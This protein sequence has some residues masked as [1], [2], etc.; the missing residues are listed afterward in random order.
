MRRPGRRGAPPR[1]EAFSRDEQIQKF[2]PKFARLAD[3]LSRP[4][5]ALELTTDPMAL[6]PER[7][8]VFEVRGS[9][10]NFADAV[11]KVHGLEFIDEEELGADEFDKNPVAYLLVPDAKALNNILAIW[12]RW[13][14]GQELDLG[15]ASWRDVFS[16]L[17][18]LRPWGPNDRLHDDERGYLIDEIEDRPDG[19]FVKLEIE[20][21]FRRILSD[22][23]NAE[24]SVLRAISSAGGRSVDRSRREDIAYH[25]LLVE[26][27]VRAVRRIVERSSDSIAGLEAVMHIRPQSI[28]PSID[29]ADPSQTHPLIRRLPEELPILALIDG[30]PIAAHPLLSGRLVIDDP[31]GLEPDTPAA[32]RV[33]GTAMASLIVHGDRNKSEASLPR[34]IHVVP[35]MRWDGF[36]EGFSGDRLIVDVIYEAV[37]RMRD[38]TEPTA[39][40]VLIVNLSLGNVRRPFH[41][42]MSPWARLLD[43]L[44]WRYGILFI[45]SAGNATDRFVIPAYDTSI[46]LEDADVNVRSANTLAAVHGLAAERRVISP[47]ETLNGITVGALN[48]D[49]VPLSERRTVGSNIEPYPQQRIS[50]PSS[51]L[52]P[53]F[54]NSIKPEILMP[55]GREHLRILGGG[56]GVTVAPAGPARAFG[57]KVAAPPADGNEATER[58]T[59]GT[60]AAAAL[61]SRTCHRIHDALE[62]AY[63]AAFTDLS[64]LQRSILLKALLV[65]PARWPAGTPQFIRDKIGPFGRGQSSKQKDNIR[66]FIGYGAFD[67]DDAV[68]CAADRATFWAT[69][70]LNRE[71]SSLI[72]VPVPICIGGKAR[73]HA[74]WAT[75]AWFTPVQPGRR[76]YRSVRLSLLDPGEIDSL[77]VIPTLL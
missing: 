12:T 3:V 11:R 18:G 60:S 6:A 77:S 58:Y 47:A 15:F 23:E 42:Q 57:L 40:T 54:A 10:Q 72:E 43:R 34:K 48:D 63:G 71:E 52:G 28:A 2:G 19:D 39:A 30:V 22:S 70:I 69:G 35:V 36:N 56:E 9:V 32:N 59:G 74:L 46:A 41:G 49:S 4:S 65:H 33:H 8:L 73:P 14:N 37:F 20:L 21:V 45:V 68:A 13:S 50:N 16:L 1:P 27:P 61:A 76:S 7:L 55:G 75:L 66:R 25:A 26:L 5:A 29:V 24:A 51:R 67:A 53:G 38:G 31:F 64:H 62:A 44:S 17:R